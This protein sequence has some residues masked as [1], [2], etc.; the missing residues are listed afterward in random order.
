MS[1]QM[2]LALLTFLM[3]DVEGSTPLWER[4]E[5]IMRQ[6]MARHDA[7]LDAVIGAHGGRRVRERG[8][9]DSIFAVFTSPSAAVAAVC[10]A[11][12]A[13]LAEPWPVETPIKVRMA[14][15]TGEAQW[16][17][18]DYYG[19]V[20][21]RCARLRGLGHGGQILLSTATAALVRSNLPAGASLRGLGAHTLK[22]MDQGEE[23]FQLCHPNLP[24]AFPPLLS[25]ETP[26]S[27]L[28]AAPTG[29][30]GREREQEQVLALQAEHQLVTLVGAGGVGKTRLAL[31]VA[32]ELVDH[33]ADGVW[34]VELAALVEPELVPMTVA[35]TLGIREEPGRPILTTLTEQLKH[36]QALLVLDNCEHLVDACAALV[37]ALLQTCR[38]VRVLA[39]GRD[40]LR[41]RGEQ[42][43]R[44]PSLSVPETRQLPPLAL[45][46]AGAVR[47]FV[48]RAQERQPSFA[49]S[50]RN[51][52][53]VVEV[54]A[55]LGGIPLAIELAAAR[56]A[57][58]PVEAI[59]TRLD[60]RFRLLTGG[61]RDALPRQ[62]TLQ[63]TLDWSYDLL[64]AS[65]QLM[66]AR[67]AV[68]AGG[69]TLEAAE[70][71]CTAE[72][73]EAWEALDLIEGLVNK[74]LAQLEESG[75]TPRYRMLES[76][77]QY[78]W[79]RLQVWPARD[80]PESDATQER[81]LAWCVSLAEQAAHELTG[82]EQRSWLTRL[83]DEHDNLRAA[84][85]NALAPASSA[86]TATQG[87]ALAGALWH[88][89]YLRG[90]LSEG[91]HW[92]EGALARAPENGS[93]EA[94]AARARALYGAGTLAYMQDDGAH[95]VE[96]LQASLDLY[97]DL[98]AR[99]EAAQ[100]LTGL[101]NVAFLRGDYA[102]TTELYGEALRAQRELG[103]RRGMGTTLNNLAHVSLAR[104]DFAEAARL[105]DESLALRRALG[106]SHAIAMSISS[107]AAIVHEL[108]DFARAE[109]LYQE[110]L[111]M[112]RDMGDRQGEAVSLSEFAGALLESGQDVAAAIP[113]FRESLSLYQSLGNRWGVAGCL[114]GLAWS[115]LEL[116]P[117]R[118]VRL[119]GA[120]AA[121]RRQIEEPPLPRM[122]VVRDRNEAALRASLG[123]A[124]FEAEWAV[125][126][127]M[128]AERVLAEALDGGAVHDAS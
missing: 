107:M 87:M 24:A 3:T 68:F 94:R 100:A 120:A 124:A 52:G 78:G 86:E 30:I 98:G 105:Q 35:Q 62:R 7:L 21:N 102:R 6:V 127:V 104:G 14:L 44:V 58:M 123:E 29:L 4:H 81:H 89:W 15:H 49:L 61:P 65:E 31:A 59:A 22:G 75:E 18:G 40:A 9:G 82:P 10:A 115:W 88:F 74:S 79:R 99:R 13:L 90:H 95:A 16:R 38:R 84:L 119:L 97:R 113:L 45:L 117:R 76:V 17:D 27:N 91:R 28:P 47:L 114:E 41:V 125:G 50:E 92:L 2:N 71:V 121:I 101:G 20:V 5:P 8:E 110:S 25:Q 112:R 108:G 80:R 55:R 118:A 64:S 36:R 72:G 73:S 32:A 1:E 126:A 57:A 11:G 43:Y 19:P 42:R 33:Y 70:A 109:A 63:A 51:A 66:L 56:V 37:G 67:L 46:D 122:R 96:R 106:D 116:D 39:T 111:A 23:V 53:A 34:L 54:C 69:W 93:A 83:E 48:A 12:L 85:G 77:R 103:D 60:D 128:P 26:N